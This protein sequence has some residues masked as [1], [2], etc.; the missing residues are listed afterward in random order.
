MYTLFISTFDEIITIG[1]LKDG[2][3][4]T[5]LEKESN[6]SHSILL[7]P[8]IEEVLGA[9]NIDTKDLNE[10][11]VVNGP[12]SFTGVRLG[13]TVAKTLAYTLNIPIKT[14]T[15]VEAI[16]ASISEHDKIVMISDPKGEYIGRFA[17]DKLEE[18]IY[19]KEEEV[20]NYLENYKVGVYNKSELDLDK[21]YNYSLNLDTVKAHAVKAIY[22]KGIEALNGK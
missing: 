10:I 14:I 19:L 4:V 22:V 6:R 12:G 2:K 21:I 17:G 1:L 3:G 18:L 16:A 11:I 7:V 20:N 13:I 5:K 8:M 15:S 9:N